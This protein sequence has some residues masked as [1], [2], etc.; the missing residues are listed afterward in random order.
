MRRL[1]S[2]AHKVTQVVDSLLEQGLSYLVLA[3]T[4]VITRACWV[5]LHHLALA[6][7]ISLLIS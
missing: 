7:G 6:F 5:A 1:N 4:L 2:H 3:L